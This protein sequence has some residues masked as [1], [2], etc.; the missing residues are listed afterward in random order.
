MT[1]SIR[2]AVFPVAGLGTRF[3]PATKAS[4]KEMLPVVDKPLIQY[5]VEEAVAAGVEVMVF[6]TGRNKTA[7]SNHF[8]TAYELEHELESRN[9]E[10]ML[11]LVRNITPPHVSCVFIRQNMPLGL[12][13]AVLC[14][15][16]VVGDE[17]FAVILADDL[18]D[19]GER[20]CLAQMVE[21]FQQTRCSILATEQVPPEET[22]SYG[23]V[24]TDGDGRLVPVRGIVEKPA[25]AEAP[26][27]RGVVGRYLLTPGIF[28]ELV[29]TGRGAGGEI[30]LTDGIARLLQ[31]EPVM[32]Y[33]FEGVRYDCGSKLGYLQATVDY[34][35][36]HHHLGEEFQ[37]WLRQRYG[38]G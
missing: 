27:N 6:V 16:P 12:G 14:A 35:V 34:A 11:R 5:A 7:I 9:K 20:G 26:S 25:P 30:Q 18:I 38:Q 36:Q 29:R 19:D 8:D 24:A 33:T 31:K 23:I 4:P 10:E 13:H 32:A 2:K 1:R 3:L 28:R 37:A 22:A 17:P 15:E 21:Q